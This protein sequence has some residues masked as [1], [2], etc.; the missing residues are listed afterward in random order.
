MADKKA[1]NTVDNNNQQTQSTMKFPSEIIDLPS[2]GKLY[3][4]DSPI[5]N[6]KIELKYM[7]AKEEDI[8]TSQNLIKKGV[9][10]DML[11]NSLIV[12]PGV[13]VNDLLLGDKNAVM[14]ASRIL[15]YGPEYIVNIT[16]PD[17]G[18]K[19]EHTFDLSQLEFKEMPADIEFD[20]NEFEFECPVMKNKIKFKLL[21]GRDEKELNKDLK[22]MSKI[23]T[24]REL[25][26]RMKAAVLAIDG[27]EDRGLIGNF[28]DNML[29]RDALAFRKHLR[30]LQPDIEVK[31]NIETE[32]GNTVEVAIPMTVNFFWPSD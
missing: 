30:E 3:P 8:L 28:I 6:G 9:V 15:A 13:D 17:T 26:T 7:T 22:A 11:L 24:D 19:R 2:G 23:G 1:K 31:Q 32:E 18:N 27:N 10:I 25:T 12:T 29:S 16:D 20:K 4:E 14:I 5:R 21:M